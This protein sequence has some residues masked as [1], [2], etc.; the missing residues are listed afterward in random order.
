MQFIFRGQFSKGLG[1]QTSMGVTF[2]G[3]EPSDVTDAPAITWLDGHP[4]YER[5][6]EPVAEEPARRRIVAAPVPKKPA[7]KA[8]AKAKK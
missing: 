4:D 2:R 1:S 3:R 8:K 5:V 7:K 6:P